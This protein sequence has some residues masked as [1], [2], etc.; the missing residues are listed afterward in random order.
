[1]WQ[2]VVEYRCKVIIVIIENIHIPME[3]TE[4]NAAF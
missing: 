1:M 3:V 4:E 2:F